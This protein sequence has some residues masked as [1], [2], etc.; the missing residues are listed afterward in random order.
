VDRSIAVRYRAS[1]ARGTAV[2]PSPW[3]TE[4]CAWETENERPGWGQPSRPGL[5]RTSGSRAQGCRVA[6]RPASAGY[7]RR[8]LE[9]VLAG[10]P[11]LSGALCAGYPDVFDA[12]D[13]KFDDD[14]RARI[15]FAQS[16]CRYTS[17]GSTTC[18]RT[19]PTARPYISMRAAH[20]GRSDTDGTGQ[21][22]QQCALGITGCPTVRCYG[23]TLRWGV[24]WARS[25]RPP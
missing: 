13:G 20:R 22:A 12:P 6:H 4:T 3:R 23:W 10:T 25:T 1:G 5:P 16:C 17:P 8:L 14:T 7:L 19:T 21:W 11:R 18:H 2:T 9:A 24:G 15:A